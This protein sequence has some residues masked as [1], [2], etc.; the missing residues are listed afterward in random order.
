M[1]L[2]PEQLWFLEQNGYHHPSYT[3]QI[4]PE[5]GN[6]Q[7]PPGGGTPT[8]PIPGVPQNPI[9]TGPTTPTA[10]TVPSSPISGTPLDQSQWR[11][12][13]K[14]GRTALPTDFMGW[15]NQQV[16]A[17]RPTWEGKTNDQNLIT[18][19]LYKDIV[20]QA[21]KN[22]GLM[23]DT[24]WMKPVQDLLG[25]NPSMSDYSRNFGANGGTFQN[26]GGFKGTSGMP[27]TA[28]AGSQTQSQNGLLG[29]GQRTAPAKNWQIISDGRG[30]YLQQKPTLSTLNSAQSNSM[31][32]SMLGNQWNNQ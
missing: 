32:S 19:G 6:T 5:P 7:L 16:S 18:H 11:V 1:A 2:T 14:A 21:R 30:S 24:S 20:G 15:V 9:P 4:T 13:P 25:W 28:A 10:P 3:P 29:S 27:Q 8:G 31:W 12:K 23:H 26:G 22:F 17:L